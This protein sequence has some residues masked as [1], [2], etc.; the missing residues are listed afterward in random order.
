MHLVHTIPGFR[1]SQGPWLTLT[2]LQWMFFILNVKFS[3]KRIP[4]KKYL[5]KVI[6]GFMIQSKI[7]DSCDSGFHLLAKQ[8]SAQSLWDSARA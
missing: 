5:F 6:L 3:S 8:Y 2:L 1:P 7:A 4:F